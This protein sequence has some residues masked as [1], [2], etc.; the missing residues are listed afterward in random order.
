MYSKVVSWVLEVICVQWVPQN[1]S[2]SS[3][4]R[5]LMLVHVSIEAKVL[6]VGK[7]EHFSSMRGHHIYTA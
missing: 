3:I 2:L 5:T 1:L 6:T 4:S 7:V